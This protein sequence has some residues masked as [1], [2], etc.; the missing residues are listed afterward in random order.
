MSRGNLSDVNPCAITPSLPAYHQR[1]GQDG[2]DA[3]ENSV[4]PWKRS[5]LFRYLAR[6]GR[7]RT[8]SRI[9]NALR[10]RFGGQRLIDRLAVVTRRDIELTLGWSIA[11][12]PERKH[13]R[14]WLEWLRSNV[15]RAD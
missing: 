8:G 1:G 5:S 14:A 3:D 10:G 4:S 13:V 6:A 9:P 7:R 15:G 12:E 11:G 2:D